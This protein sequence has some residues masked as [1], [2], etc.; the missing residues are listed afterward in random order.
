L[1]DKIWQPFLFKTFT[2]LT[3]FFFLLL[4]I[5]TSFVSRAQITSVPEFPVASDEITITFNSAEENRLGYFTGDLYAHTG[6]ITEESTSDNDWQYVIEGWGNNTTQPQLTNKGNGIYELV[7][8][9]DVAT[10]YS[11]AAGE[12]VLKIALVFRSADA[13]QQTNN[14]YIDIYEGGLVVD[15]TEPAGSSILKLNTPTT[16][17]ARSSV[18]AALKLSIN[19]TILVENNGTEITTNHTFSESGKHWL[20]A[21]ATANGETVFDSMEIVVRNEV[22]IEPKPANYKKGIN[23]TGDTSAALVL[24]APLKEFVYVIG[25]F[26][27]W[28]ISDDYLMKKDGDYFWLDIS[29]LE[30]GT[31]YIFQYYIDGVIKIADPYTEK[32]VDPWNDQ[33][34]PEE[35]YPD[36]IAYPGEKTEGIASVLQTAQEEYNW[37]VSDFQKPDKNK[38][39]I[40][41]LLVRDFTTDQSY[42]GVIDQ[43]DY[44]EDLRIN[45][46]ELM[47][48]NEFEGNNSWGYNPSFYF[49]PDKYYGPKNKLKELIDECHKRGIAVVIDMV[50]NHSYGQSP[51]LQMYMNN[52]V[53]TDENPWYN[54]ESP[55][56]TYSWGVD[57]NH[58]ADVVKELVDSIN[59]FWINEYKIDGFRFDFT[60]G[61]TQTAGDGWAYDAS[62][63]AILKRMANEIW[64]RNAET[65]V[66]LEHLAHN[67]EETELANAGIMLWGNMHGSYQN[68]AA[69][70]TSE[71]DLS[72]AVYEERGWNEPNLVSYP[73]SHDEERIMYTIKNTG[74]SNDVYNIRNQ[75][76]A[77]K[78]IELNAL[79]HLLLPGPKMIWQ[80]GE[81]GYDLPINRCEDGSI[82]NDCRLAP[83]PPYWQYLNNPDR[84]ELFHVMAKLNE[85]KQHYEVFTPTSFS[86]NL[87]G[88]G[89]WFIASNASNHAIALGNFDIVEHDVAITFPKTGKYYEFFTQDSIEISST[90]QNFTFEAGEYRLYS[91]QKFEDPDVTT[92][93]KAVSAQKNT[94][95]MYPNPANSVLNF[96]SEV[97]IDRIEIYSLTGKLMLLDEEPANQKQI[98]IDSFVSGIYLV[99]TIQ[100]KNVSTQKVIVN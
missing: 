4:M 9:P 90:N 58:E 22:A 75:T 24:W 49:A 31:E 19:E 81:R 1:P 35:V 53:P 65:F 23:Y 42:Q 87:S 57:F 77:L 70:N 91:T 72:W 48:V 94:V 34:I 45:V 8:T 78:R 16:F 37:Q 47:P 100:G 41:E 50:L 63:I 21:E 20:I 12:K 67:A 36:L 99:R 93:L 85:L 96:S 97:A 25:D 33:Y 32:I 28:E 84:V 7:I 54:I 80:F 86:H 29:N 66:I 71:S 43:L 17:T 18:S 60:K 3:R 11:V 38:L 40:Y 14:L 59:S 5:A 61:F 83:K 56:Q 6:L 62:R 82:N 2:M 79:F 27:N 44:L 88:A 74:L 92:D 52:Y 68:A 51:F 46:L 39:A 13:S 69:G 30:K 98:D 64:Q 15:I 73:E 10:Y 89:K 76:T 26:N 55:N 95:S